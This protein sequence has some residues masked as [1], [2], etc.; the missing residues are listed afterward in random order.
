[1]LQE[2]RFAVLVAALLSSQTK[3][4]VTHAAV[5][6]LRAAGLLTL[7]GMLGAEQETVQ[8]LIYPVSCLGPYRLI[9]PRNVFLGSVAALC[10]FERWPRIGFTG[11]NKQKDR[12]HLC[13]LRF[14]LLEF[15]A[16]CLH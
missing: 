4:A 13:S 9:V 14:Y 7:E 10:P 8:K 1:V 15:L 12:P 16:S 11:L 5:E 6:R 3:D 2:R